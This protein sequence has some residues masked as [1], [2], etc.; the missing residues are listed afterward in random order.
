MS[1]AERAGEPR[2]PAPRLIVITDTALAPEP[3]LLERLERALAAAQPDTVMVQLRDRE[4]GARARL[5]LG[6]R[7]V[8]LCRRHA[9]WFAVND[10]LDLAVLLGADGVHLG[11]GGVEVADARVLL[12]ASA[13]ISCARHAPGGVAIPGA[14]AVLLSPIAAPRKG[15]PA[16]GIPALQSAHAALASTA[17]RDRPLLYALG[18][19]DASNAAACLSHGAD[20]VAVIGAIL[21][22]RDPAGLLD[23]L[24]ILRRR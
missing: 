22:G 21:D 13:W 8:T 17:P 20:G 9:Q 14:D 11:E 16:L 18:G 7:L 15:N 5:A 23:A 19:I 4:L 6:R 24:G 12:G 2:R 10:R 3:I 1:A